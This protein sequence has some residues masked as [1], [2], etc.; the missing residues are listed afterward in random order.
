MTGPLCYRCVHTGTCVVQCTFDLKRL[1]SMTPRSYLHICLHASTK[2]STLLVIEPAIGPMAILPVPTR[3][4]TA[5]I[6][7]P[8]MITSSGMHP[9]IFKN[10]FRLIA[11]DTSAKQL[12][13]PLPRVLEIRSNG[14]R[15]QP[16]I[17]P[18]CSSAVGCHGCG[19]RGGVDL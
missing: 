1:D 18:A 13:L 11:V 12:G 6:A 16:E 5:T 2:D 3:A 9:G 10:V 14:P 4:S 15:G 7:I 17:Q 8:S 19:R